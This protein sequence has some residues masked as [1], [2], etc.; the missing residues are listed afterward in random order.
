MFVM[1]T[2]MTREEIL[3]VSIVFFTIPIQPQTTIVVS[4]EIG[5]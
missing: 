3:V 4:I 5:H 1:L 2:G